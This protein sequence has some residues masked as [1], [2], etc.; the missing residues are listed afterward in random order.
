MKKTFVLSHPKIAYPRLIEAAKH[1]IRKYL[2]RERK[3]TLPEGADYWDFDCKFGSIEADAKV[4]H[5]AE[6][7]PAINQAAA[8]Q[9]PQFYVEIVAKPGHR[10]K[11]QGEEVEAEATPPPKPFVLNQFS[12]LEE[13]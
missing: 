3:K 6:I 2:K 7:D 5:L 12:K 4:V 1:D 9:A 10:A 13:D 8:E 11:N